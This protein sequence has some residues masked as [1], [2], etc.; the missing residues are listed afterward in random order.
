MYFIIKN[1]SDN[2]IVHQSYCKTPIISWSICDYL[3]SFDL[4][5]CQIMVGR[6]V[7]N[8]YFNRKFA[9][10]LCDLW[11]FDSERT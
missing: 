11:G 2:L 1:A 4:K 7:L 10:D 5:T 9:I 6:R 8:N 3:M